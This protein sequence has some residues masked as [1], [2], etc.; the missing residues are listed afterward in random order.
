MRKFCV[1]LLVLVVAT[2]MLFAE[3]LIEQIDRLHDEEQHQE[4]Y[5]LIKGAIGSAQGNVEK[6]LAGFV[7][8]RLNKV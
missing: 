8:V 4:N 2:G 3:T 1:L 7:F 6:A 5:A